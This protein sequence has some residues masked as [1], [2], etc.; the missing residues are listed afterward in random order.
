MEFSKIDITVPNEIGKFLNTIRE[1]DKD[2]VVIGD[3][4]YSLY[5]GKP[6]KSVDVYASREFFEETT[7]SLSSR[8]DVQYDE[9]D[10]IDIAT[11]CSY[12][13]YVFI[14]HFINTPQKEMYYQDL[15]LREFYYDGKF[16]YATDDAIKDHEEKLMHI[17]I[18]K[19]PLKTHIDAHC[20]FN[21]YGIKLRAKTT[22]LLISRFNEIKYSGKEIKDYIEKNTKGKVKQYLEEIHQEMEDTDIVRL[23]TEEEPNK[24]ANRY[25]QAYQYKIERDIFQKLYLKNEFITEEMEYEFKISPFYEEI[26]EKSEEIKNEFKKQLVKLM[27]HYPD[28]TGLWKGQLDDKLFLHLMIPKIVDRIKKEL[29]PKEFPLDK[30]VELLK[31]LDELTHKASRM[32]KKITIHSTSQFPIRK[33]FNVYRYLK[34]EYRLVTFSKKEDGIFD[35][36]KGEFVIGTSTLTKSEKKLYEIILKKIFRPKGEGTCTSSI[37]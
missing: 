10:L 9:V 23:K 27:F 29:T 6:G 35:M 2:A 36:K 30:V 13:E 28:E 32:K 37:L 31:E 20:Y 16:A 8:L 17:G 21:D 22:Q 7:E 26:K 14:L 4:L 34:D 18:V 12:G 33:G 19:N 5:A 24:A 25:L 1:N 15:S 3:Y 11:V